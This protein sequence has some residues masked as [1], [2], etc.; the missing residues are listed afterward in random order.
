MSPAKRSATRVD[1]RTAWQTQSLLLGYPDDQYVARLT[2]LRRVAEHCEPAVG[3]PL[4][5]FLDHIEKTPLPELAAV[6][7]ETFDHRRRCCL[8]L[9]YYAHGDTRK[10]GMA[11]L[12]LKQTYAAAGMRLTDEELPDHLG[13]ILEYASAHHDP[14]AG[15]D[16][17]GEH[18]AGIEVL[19]LAL[20]DAASPWARVLDSISATLP[21]LRGDQRDAVAR[22]AAEGPPDEQVGLAPFAPPEFIPWPQKAPR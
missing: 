14:A 18:R 16:L 2:L 7:V 21:P 1:H 6:Y 11:L 15:G 22:L 8:Y 3:T 12:K 4:A 20:A 9:T 10:R 19:R 5:D 17:L 13:V